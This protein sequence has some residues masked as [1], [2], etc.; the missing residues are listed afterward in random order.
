[1]NLSKS[2]FECLKLGCDRRFDSGDSGWQSR[3]PAFASVNCGESPANSLVSQ[4]ELQLFYPGPL[5]LHTIANDNLSAARENSVA[6]RSQSRAGAEP[7]RG[8]P[9]WAIHQPHCQLEKVTAE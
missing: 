1:M 5:N 3:G 9:A 8:C 7:E 4:P 6:L 2:S